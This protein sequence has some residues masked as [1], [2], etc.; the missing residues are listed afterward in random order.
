MPY[1][2]LFRRDYKINPSYLNF[3]V[4]WSFFVWSGNFIALEYLEIIW[5]LIQKGTGFIFSNFTLHQVLP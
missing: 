2:M 3:P 4:V 5:D 1:F